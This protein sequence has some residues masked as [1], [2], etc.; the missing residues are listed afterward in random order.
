MCS[1]TAEWQE[2]RG[3]WFGQCRL[4]PSKVANK[5]GHRPD[6]D[7]E[8]PRRSLPWQRFVCISSRRSWV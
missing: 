3:E 7:P 6:G 2:R 4:V 8:R 5:T 1:L